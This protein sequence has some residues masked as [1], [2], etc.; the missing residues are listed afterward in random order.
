MGV[1]EINNEIRNGTISNY[2]TQ[3]QSAINSSNLIG[4]DSTTTLNSVKKQSSILINKLSNLAA[5]AASSSITNT[6]NTNLSP[7]N[8]V[9]DKQSVLAS[10]PSLLTTVSNTNDPTDMTSLEILNKCHLDLFPKKKAHCDDEKCMS[11]VEQVPILHGE[12]IQFIGK[13]SLN[14]QSIYI[15]FF[16]AFLLD[17]F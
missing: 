9:P 1:V 2:D 3:H 17:I 8:A 11:I 16:N 15:H 5:A 13:L 7:S 14:G 12:Y 10:S 4:T 6:D